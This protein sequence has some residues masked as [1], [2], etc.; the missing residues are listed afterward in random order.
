MPD[1]KSVTHRQMRQNTQVVHLNQNL[2]SQLMTVHQVPDVGRAHL[3]ALQHT[4][5]L[6]GAGIGR[7]L[8]V[9]G[10]RIRQVGV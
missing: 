6:K 8:A 9:A 5:R 10:K 1:R 7:I 2:R 3:T 4:S